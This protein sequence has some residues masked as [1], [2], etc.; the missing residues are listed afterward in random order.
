MLK[1][2]RLAKREIR[3]EEGLARMLDNPGPGACGI[4]AIQ[5][6]Q[7]ASREVVDLLL[8]GLC[9]NDIR[10]GEIL[11][12]NGR[13]IGDGAGLTLRTDN[14]ES[15]KGMQD[16]LHYKA[17]EVALDRNHQTLHGALF[18]IAREQKGAIREIK[19]KIGRI[20]TGAGFTFLRFERATVD[21]SAISNRA[22]EVM[23]EI[24]QLTFA[25]ENDKSEKSL[26]ALFYARLEIERRLPGV[27]PVSLQ[28]GTMT[29]KGM[30]R[31]SEMR[32]IYPDL[33]REDVITDAGLA[34][35][36]FG[37]NTLAKWSIAQ[38]FG[39][40]A[41]NGEVNSIRKILKVLENLERAQVLP[42]S[43]I[44]RNAS[45]SA[46]L[47]RALQFLIA[48]G[49]SLE[50]AVR[51]MI[52]PPLDDLMRMRDDI[53]DYF[54]GI[55][56]AM[57]S[58][59]AIGP[60]ALLGM[61]RNKIVAALDNMGLRPLRI[62]RRADG[63]HIIA[64]EVGMPN[65]EDIVQYDRVEPGGISTLDR[66]STL[67]RTTQTDA[68]IVAKTP[69]NYKTIAEE[70]LSEL[71][72]KGK[73]PEYIRQVQEGMESQCPPET[74][75][76]RAHLFGLNMDRQKR[77]KASIEVGKDPVEGMGSDLA[78]ACFS[79]EE[80]S[81]GRFITTNWSQVSNPSLDY[82]REQGPFTTETHLGARPQSDKKHPFKYKTDR[83]YQLSDPLL[84][85]DQITALYSTD[86]RH[87][88]TRQT[89]ST[90]YPEQTLTSCQ[91]RI[92]E[93]REQVISSARGKKHAIIV[94]SDRKATG[95]GDGY[96]PPHVLVAYLSRELDKE[97]L[98][99]G[100]SLVVD[101]GEVLD[102]HEFNLLISCG[103]KAVH[104]RIIYEQIRNRQLS[105]PGQSQSEMETNLRKSFQGTLLRYMAKLGLTDI[106][107]YRGSQQFSTL[108]L[109]EDFVR[110]YFRDEVETNGGGI[111][112]EELLKMQWQRARTESETPG[113]GLRKSKEKHGYGTAIWQS[114]HQVGSL[115]ARREEDTAQVTAIQA[116]GEDDIKALM[117]KITAEEKR[118]WEAYR[119]EAKKE[120]ILSNRDTYR[121]K[122]SATPVPIE[123]VMST[124]DIIRRVIRGAGISLG[125]I[126]DQAH[127]AIQI[128]F[129]HYG[130]MAN[131][132]EG[133]VPKDRR[134]GQ[135]WEKAGPKSLQVASG[136]FGIDIESL[137]NPQVEEIEI[138][139]GQGA[140]PGVGGH[141][142]GDKTFPLVAEI[143]GVSLGQE[144][145][146][147][148]TNHDIYSIEDL[149]G[150]LDRLG[151]C[152]PTAKLSVKITSGYNVGTIAAG[153]KK[154]GADKIE[155]SGGAGGTGAATLTDKFNTGTPVEFGLSE[156]DRRMVEQGLRDGTE[157]GADG[158]IRNGEDI[159]KLIALGANNISI[160]TLLLIS[161]LKCIFCQ[162][163]STQKCPAYITRS[164][165]KFL[166][167]SRD[168][169][170][171]IE[172]G[173]EE[174]ED[175]M[176]RLLYT[177]M[178]TLEFLAQEIREF[179]AEMGIRDIDELVGKRS[180]FLELDP[181]AVEQYPWLANSF[182]HDIFLAKP[183]PIFNTTPKTA[184]KETPQHDQNTI[185]FY[186]NSPKVSKANREII[187]QAVNG[188][189]KGD[190]PLN[191]ELHHVR[192]RDRDLGATLGCLIVR[193]LITPP[194]KGITIR[195]IGKAGQG[196]GTGITAG[197]T[198]IHTGPIQNEGAVFQNGGKI[199]VL[200]PLPN[201]NKQ[202]LIG[203]T[204][205]YGSRGGDR[206][207]Q[208]STGDRTCV[209]ETFGRT[210]I[211]GDT[212]KYFAGY[213]TGGRD[214]V[215][216]KLGYDTGAGMSGGCIY[217]RDPDVEDKLAKGAAT[218][219]VMRQ[220][221]LEIIKTDLE[222]F[223]ADTR[224]AEVGAI[225]QNWNKE[226]LSFRKIV[227]ETQ[228]STDIFRMAYAK[229]V[230]QREYDDREKSELMANLLEMCG[231]DIDGKK[232]QPVIEQIDR[233]LT[234]GLT[235]LTEEIIPDIRPV[236]EE[237][238][239]MAT[240]RFCAKLAK[241][242]KEY[243]DN[244]R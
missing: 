23:P 79:P 214:I 58:L 184:N 96:I 185:D 97:G 179:M 125:A 161:Q 60:I 99:S 70:K 75:Q 218:T 123:E 149:K 238:H 142:P 190:D 225:L 65:T 207:I 54:M 156:S 157:L 174:E 165:S 113:K 196:Y 182:N 220:R 103:A 193:G 63:M 163:C 41:H 229:I 52:H 213:K 151:A 228:Y 117:P 20:M 3:D 35:T 167:S 211:S 108:G 209:R 204:L 130:S 89:I 8:D 166:G 4:V 152:N 49:L 21:P 93:I 118:I 15:G 111:S 212:G 177:G 176:H 13:P 155:I 77:L 202:A 121:L 141:L 37:T 186:L 45:D 145:I 203:N 42:T 12:A 28:P 78:M 148:P 48:K 150:L 64:S 172:Y 135:P 119:T 44:M 132:G 62:V 241:G 94:L 106:D 153:C 73:D 129:N 114:L 14:D 134:I 181:A 234:M 85:H 6:A 43:N 2:N 51:W 27:F 88:P 34:H 38:P 29:W 189:S 243:V 31:G 87:N 197:V 140:K 139:I 133:G 137:A 92:E 199:V 226:K 146:S 160:G 55:S 102:Q 144:L 128:L 17:G 101:T 110:Q 67:K 223:Y 40:I 115:V 50:E 25:E 86:K 235:Q 22:Q 116:M 194:S 10:A 91:Q 1:E 19:E 147:P 200:S 36:R 231:I 236:S 188:L 71:R 237:A 217:T 210:I 136:R 84:D 230:D 104:P 33:E 195:T 9:D 192:P 127:R 57:G 206:F 171:K 76:Q 74:Y 244:T 183:E 18:F 227:A 109:A 7:G 159:L 126:N 215:L 105:I 5:S 107:S 98:S 219:S 239:F 56:R 169:G 59:K 240:Q 138:K 154:A 205:A 187:R 233:L 26:K 191:I 221:D 178:R 198:M 164:I 120:G 222:E 143:R 61:D 208:G 39:L 81:I 11:D 216:G 162:N 47:D 170:E 122:K 168:R 173:T 112:F 175:Q 232:A 24:Y 90:V 158:G 72:T 131:S 46:N 180:E 83:Q 32:G 66:N 242:I 80:N 95:N 16:Y 124:D 30:F 82:M 53:R 201:D 68:E 224:D 69:V 100:V